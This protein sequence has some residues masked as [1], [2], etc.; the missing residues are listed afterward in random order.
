MKTRIKLFSFSLITIVGV[1][2]LLEMFSRYL[3]YP[4]LKMSVLESITSILVK[5][6]ELFW[7]QKA[8]LKTVFF[9]QTL[10]LDEFGLR[11]PEGYVKQKNKNEFRIVILGASPSLGWGVKNEQSYSSL[12][13]K[14]LNNSSRDSMTKV[15]VINASN[16]GY[17]S[18]QGVKFFKNNVHILKPDCLMISY[19]VND[20]SKERF[21]YSSPLRDSELKISTETIL[22]IFFS[23]YFI[24]LLQKILPNTFINNFPPNARV[25]LEEY[26]ANHQEIYDMAKQLNIPVILVLIPFQFP[27]VESPTYRQKEMLAVENRS[28]RYFAALEN[29]AQNRQIAVLRMNQLLLDTTSNFL[30]SQSDYIHPSPKGHE[31]IATLLHDFICNS[32]CILKSKWLK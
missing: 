31:I 11:N 19:G 6:S 17:S 7:K 26:I 9:G 15:K 10:E 24:K 1:F 12:L 22:D 23:F 25:S 5:D 16:I 2:F 32:K 21:F 4:H 20:V 18:F 8:N 29:W 27:K 30:S 13:E 14:K 28:I 3:V